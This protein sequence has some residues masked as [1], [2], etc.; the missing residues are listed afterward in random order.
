MAKLIDVTV[1]CPIHRALG[2]LRV[3]QLS[4]RATRLRLGFMKFLRDRVDR[5]VAR[6]DR[7]LAAEDPRTHG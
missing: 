2:K 6:L 4:E 3:R 1:Q 7:R 5:R